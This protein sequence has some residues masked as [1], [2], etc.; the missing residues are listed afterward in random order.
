MKYHLVNWLDVCQPRD[1]GRLGVTNLEVKSI[2]LLCK[3]I[4]RLENE[5][6]DWHEMIRA[7]YLNRKTL[8]RCVASDGNSH[9]WNSLMS[10]NTGGA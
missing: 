10:L 3:W 4:W 5:E 8:T 6:G 2:T 1:Q 7:K 9:F